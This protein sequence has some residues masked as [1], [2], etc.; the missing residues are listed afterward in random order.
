MIAKQVLTLLCFLAPLLAGADPLDVYGNLT[1]K[2]VLMSSVLP[3]LS[4][5]LIADLPTEKTNAIAR[6]EN[7][8]AKQGIAVVQDGPHFVRVFP[9]DMRGLMI[10]VS[11]RGAE[12]ASLKSRPTILAGSIN[13]NGAPL[14]LVLPIYASLS[15]RTILRPAMLPRIEMRLQP[16]CPLTREEIAYAME[17]VLAL[18]G[19]AA[20]VDGERFVQVV[21]MPERARLTVRAPKPE[22]DAKL[23][24]PNKVPSTGYSD[25]TRRITDLEQNFQR[26]QKALYDFIH[27][28][29]PPDRS[30]ERLLKFYASLADKTAQSSKEFD[31]LPLWFH[32]ETPLSKSELLYAIET[33]FNLNHL[34]IINVDDQRIRLG[35]IGDPVKGSGK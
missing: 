12:L 34:T 19:I 16:T 29:G 22:P 26:L 9:E 32:T 25:P 30:A 4:D 15:R 7:D 18:N 24:D 31:G 13:F 1:E 35:R 11:L 20:V 17:T 14:N 5:A 28:K 21:P 10:N 3:R 8:L 2:T 33:T 27:F 23:L 6:I